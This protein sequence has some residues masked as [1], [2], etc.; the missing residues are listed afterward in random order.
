MVDDGVV[1]FYEEVVERDY[2]CNENRFF[3]VLYGWGDGLER[4]DGGWC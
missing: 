1:G 2:C 3:V 4:E